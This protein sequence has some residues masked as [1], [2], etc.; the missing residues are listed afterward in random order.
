[1]LL[2][3]T[4]LAGR[5]KISESSNK[6]EDHRNRNLHGTR[7][8]VDSDQFDQFNSMFGTAPTDFTFYCNTNTSTFS[9]SKLA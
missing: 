5:C 6:H 9:G 1:M 2:C 4:Q 3:A 8:N 7:A